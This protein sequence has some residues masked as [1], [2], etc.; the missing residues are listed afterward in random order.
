MPIPKLA[1]Q[2]PRNTFCKSQKSRPNQQNQKNSNKQ[3]YYF[4][5]KLTFKNINKLSLNEIF[6]EMYLFWHENYISN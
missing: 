2:Y 5:I 4:T 6:N 1:F 3:V